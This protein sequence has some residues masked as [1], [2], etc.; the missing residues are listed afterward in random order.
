MNATNFLA[1]I[2][3]Q[4]VVPPVETVQAAPI[5]PVVLAYANAKPAVT[6]SPVSSHGLQADLPMDIAVVEGDSIGLESILLTRSQS[7]GCFL[8]LV[9]KS[10]L[11]SAKVHT[12]RQ[13]LASKYQ[14]LHLRGVD[15]ETLSELRGADRL[16]GSAHTRGSVGSNYGLNI[17]R[18][19]AIVERAIELDASDI[20][21]D[22]IASGRRAPEVAIRYRVHGQLTDPDIK[23]SD[24]AVQE[25]VETI[26]GV[27]Q[28][29]SICPA[30]TRVGGNTFDFPVSRRYEATLKPPIKSAELRF[31][32]MPEKAGFFVVM[33]LISYE[34][35]SAARPSLADLGA[36][37][38]QARDLGRAA[39]APHGFILVVGATGSGKTTTITTM[40]AMDKDA[41]HKRRISLE[42]P[43]ESDIEWLSQIPTTEELLPDHADGVMR[44]DPDVISGGEIRNQLTATMAQDYSITGHLTFATFHAN[45]VFPALLRLLGPRINLDRDILVMRG[46][47][48]AVLYQALVNRLCSHC[49][50]PAVNHMQS[51][52]LDLLS[53][54]F[55]LNPHSLYVKSG[56]ITNDTACPHCKGV[57]TVGRT[58]VMELL[59]PN[60]SILAKIQQGDV[61]GAELEFRRSR[62]AHFNEPG[63]VGKT[64]VEH[65]L[66]KASQGEISAEEVFNLEELFSYEV[67]QTSEGT[68]A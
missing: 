60:S 3:K 29:S 19:F 55:G 35:K 50:A 18:A 62:T 39:A 16:A 7:L 11:D 42:I 30:T 14:P 49:K 26:R 2:R 20:H 68:S 1:R 61:N 57:G 4:D 6:A 28:D 15:H 24:L 53:S 5:T 12:I 59:I 23:R 34:G 52:K 65:A 51:E 32:A 8:L 46:F 64:S 41:K 58:S 66:Y 25:M 54:K 13:R 10:D 37:T 45:G 9:L 63:T 47:L 38:D 44:S 31:E 56:R 33:R 48:R 36:S 67:V 40:L 43:P 27:Y 17:A 21:I 22:V